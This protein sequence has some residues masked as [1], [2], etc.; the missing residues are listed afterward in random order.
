[1]LDAKRSAGVALE[2]SVESIMHKQQ[3]SQGMGP[4]T[5]CNPGQASPEVQNKNT[6][7]PLVVTL[8]Y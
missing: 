8:S 6:S 3:I 7:C 4:P 5:F 2:E 1:M